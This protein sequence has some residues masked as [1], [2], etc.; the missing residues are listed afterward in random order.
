MATIT[1]AGVIPSTP[2]Q[3]NDQLMAVSTSLAPGL[4]STLPGSL[5]EDMSSTATGAL[6][7]QDQAYVDLLNSV[8]PLTANPF[9]LNQLGAVY[10]VQQGL[11]SNTTVYVTFTGT[12]GFVV[13]PG[14]IVGDGTYQYVVQ[15]GGIVGTSGSTHALY[16]VATTAGSWAIPIGA[17]TTLIT[18]VPSTITLTCTNSA[19]GTPGAASQDT[20]DYQAQVIQAGLAASQGM[21]TFLKTAIGNVSGVI[22]RTI[23]YRPS[24]GG[25]QILAAGGDP[26]A[27]GYAIFSAMFNFGDLVGAQT[28][29]TTETVS[30]FDV[31]DTYSIEYVIPAAQTIGVTA[32]WNTISNSNFISPVVVS[33]LA[34]PAIVAYINS[35]NSGQS[36][37]LLGLQDA[38][39]TSTAG[40]LSD[41]T[42]SVL[43]FTVTINGVVTAPGSGGVLIPIDPE[44]YAYTTL[45]NITV[46]QA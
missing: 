30:I 31:P 45:A 41:A 32:L 46:N 4:T 7:V 37:S 17:V 35:L 15:D 19:V 6:V 20:Q 36:I 24:S 40:L 11:G 28:V 12:I 26:Y 16:C 27:V 14:F 2:Q 18:S 34:Q 44:G 25:W 42:L 5:I 38:F 29:G 23:S 43:T 10:G 1:S 3:L 8:S 21:S 22:Q 13:N 33:G 39:K 9:I